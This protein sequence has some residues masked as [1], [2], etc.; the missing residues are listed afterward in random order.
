MMLISGFRF[1]SGAPLMKAYMFIELWQLL[2]T[3]YAT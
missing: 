2:Y 3:A 1:Y